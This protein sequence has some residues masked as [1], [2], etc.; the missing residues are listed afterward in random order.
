MQFSLG[1]AAVPVAA[2]PQACPAFDDIAT[3]EDD[4]RPRRRG[5]PREKLV[6][7][8][9]R[10]KGA[11][12]SLGLV[13]AVLVVGFAIIGIFG[14]IGLGYAMG[15]FGNGDATAKGTSAAANFADYALTVPPVPEPWVKDNTLL[16]KLG[17]NLLVYRRE[18]PDGWIAFE[19][20]KVDFEAKAS[21]LKP[22]LLQRLR[23]AFD[24]L[25][26]EIAGKETKFLGVTGEKYEFA[27]T[28][29]YHG[30]GVTC[31][32]EVYACVT[33][34]YLY[35]M[36]SFWQKDDFKDTATIEAVRNQLVHKASGEFKPK[37][38][39]PEKTFRG[40]GGEFTIGDSEGLWVQQKD[41]TLQSADAELWLKGQGKNAATGQP[42]SEKASLLVV[43]IEPKDDLAEQA[44][45]YVLKQFEDGAKIAE[46][47]EEPEG[48]APSSGPVAASDVVKR[49]TLMY[50]ETD[51]S[52]FKFVAYRAFDSKKRRI[53][54][55][56][57]CPLKERRYWE[58]RLMLILGTMKEG[59]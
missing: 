53:V 8:P 7:H 49:M 3:D 50:D 26:E 39:P 6:E 12:S 10:A 18:N 38:K 31:R 1:G 41:P 42:S 44:K 43:A 21:D 46:I 5:K 47:T 13:I 35:W 52:S 59:R 27:G 57:S 32:G 17:V 24:D 20:Q 48:D 55:F 16:A 11:K 19:A 4:N 40:P 2:P 58:Q 14:F 28:F 30:S 54:A 45:T 56:A 25:D 22:R 51:P 9:G 15:W 23:N 36:Y 37:P 33:K 34:N 29:K